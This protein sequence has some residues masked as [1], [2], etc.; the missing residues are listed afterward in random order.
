MSSNLC[1]VRWALVFILCDFQQFYPSIMTVYNY[2]QW[3]IEFRN[4]YCPWCIQWLCCDHEWDFKSFVLW[5]NNHLMPGTMYT[6]PRGN[7]VHNARTSHNSTIIPFPPHRMYLFMCYTISPWNVSIH[8]LHCWKL[9]INK[10]QRSSHNEEIRAISTDNALRRKH[11]Q[12]WLSLVMELDI[13][14]EICFGIHRSY[15]RHWVHTA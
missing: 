7:S 6:G 11:C 10:Y 5:K 14:M 15:Y 13:W 12:I 8:V 2:R 3:F 4:C 9:Y 1:V